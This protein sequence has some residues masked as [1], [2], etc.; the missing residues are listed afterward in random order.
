DGAAGAPGAAGAA[1][2]G[3]PGAPGAGGPA[4]GF[5]ANIERIVPDYVKP[6]QDR[7][8]QLRLTDEQVAK[9][10]SVQLRFRADRDKLGQELAEI[11]QKAGRNPDPAVIVSQIV[12]RIQKGRERSRKA[13][14]EAKAV[15]TPEQWA[16]LPEEVRS[17]PPPRF[18]GPGGPGGPPRP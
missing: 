11:V 9:L 13:L 14:E 12:P 4:A 8:I 16:Q 5:A 6:I 2:Q 15:L 3:Q 1:P 10:D 17:P 7:N 18:G